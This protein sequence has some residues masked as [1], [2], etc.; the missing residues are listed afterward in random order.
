MT[1]N[2]TTDK[3][4]GYS[5]VH[6]AGR[7]DTIT[8]ESLE[9]ALM[10]ILSEGEEKIILDLENVEYISSAGIRILVVIT[11][12]MYDSGELFCILSENAREIIEMAGVNTFVNICD[13]IAEAEAA[14]Q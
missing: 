10:D 12:Q 6:V 11:K 5:V 1:L 9:D 8:A 3:K 2:I 4:D 7:I 14:I 13:T